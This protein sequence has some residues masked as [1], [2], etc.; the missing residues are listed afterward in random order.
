MKFRLERQEINK[1]LSRLGH[2]KIKEHK[3]YVPRANQK[4]VKEL[5]AVLRE[6]HGKGLPS[7]LVLRKLPKKLGHGVFLLPEAKAIPRGAVIAPY[8]GEV[9][10]CPQNE[11]GSSDYL[12]SLIANFR[13]TRKEQALWDPKRRYH[14]RR[15]YAIDVDAEKKGNFTRFIN[16]SASPNVEARFLQ[17]PTNSHG[18][19][20]APFELLYVAK[21]TIR[22]GE[23]LLICYEG[24]D[25]SYW[26]AVNIKPFPMTPTTFK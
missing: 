1:I 25:R 8:S 9:L 18:L 15:L 14:P 4:T 26:G 13:L 16:H 7:Y 3:L 19:S 12:F 21:K 22:P 24:D 17:I 6:I 20:P 5:A 11:E 2:K 23:Q 10:L